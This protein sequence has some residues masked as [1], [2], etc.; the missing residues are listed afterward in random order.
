MR[1]SVTM[2]FCGKVCEL[3]SLCFLPVNGMILSPHVH[4]S[5]ENSSCFF[6]SRNWRRKRA[7]L[8]ELSTDKKVAKFG[9][10]KKKKKWGGAFLSHIKFSA[11]PCSVR[12]PSSSSS[13]LQRQEHVHK[14]REAGTERDAASPRREGVTF[15]FHSRGR[16]QESVLSKKGTA[17]FFR[18]LFCSLSSTRE[19]S[20]LSPIK[21]NSLSPSGAAF[22]R[23]SRISLQ[24]QVRF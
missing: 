13:L 10:A 4:E 6:A 15:F 3:A 5:L 21:Y 19:N 7:G 22:P 20:K 23:R 18:S 1:E 12:R 2:A 16:S 14:R 8:L 9:A 11:G 17:F 24:H